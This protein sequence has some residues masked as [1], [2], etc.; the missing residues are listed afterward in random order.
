MNS[1][2]LIQ[3][4][5]STSPPPKYTPP[6]GSSAIT[7]LRMIYHSAVT[8]ASNR[9]GM[10]HSHRRHRVVGEARELE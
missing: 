2:T 9:N 3:S 10:T 5:R 8:S 1:R 7:L 4:F 6:S